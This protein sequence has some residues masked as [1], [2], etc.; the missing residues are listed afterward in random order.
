MQNDY[1]KFIVEVNFVKYRRITTQL[2]LTIGNSQY[3]QTIVFHLHFP[4][5]HK[6]KYL[7]LIYNL[8][9]FISIST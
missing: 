3:Q 8:F 9:E 7:K 1:L 6:K 2:T 5:H 4:F